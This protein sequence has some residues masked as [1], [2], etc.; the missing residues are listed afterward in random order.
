G[1]ARAFI[2]DTG[3]APACAGAALAALG[4]LESTPELPDRVRRNTAAVARVAAEA[5]LA[6]P[7]PTAAVLPVLLGEPDRAVRA[8]AVCADH[9]VRVGCFRPPSVPPGRSCLRVTGRAD[10]T[11]GDLDRA[12]EALRAVGKELSG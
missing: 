3:L 12:A 11:P 6:V 4:V 1:A 5:G 2:F 10:L 9:G 8:A 7:D